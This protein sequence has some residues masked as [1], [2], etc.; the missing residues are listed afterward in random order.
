MSV[1][2]TYPATPSNVDESVVKPSPEF[3]KQVANTTGVI[4]LFLVVYIV[5]VAAGTALAAAC[6]IGGVL[7][8]IALPKFFTLML[9]VGLIGLG[10]M[11]LFFLLKFI[12]KQN[13]TDRSGLIEVTEEEQPELFDFIRTLTRETQAPFPKKIFLSPDVNACVF[14]DS[15]FWSMFLPVRKNLQ[16]GL[17]LVNSVN[18]SEFKAIMAHEFGHFSQRSMKL[19]SYVYNVNHVIYNMLYDNDGYDTT[20]QWWAGISDYF[21]LFAGMTVRIVRGIQWLLQQMY[22]VVNKTYMSLSRQMEFHADAVAAYVTGGDHLVTSLRRL[23]VADS[24]Y[25][26]LFRHYNS[27]YQENAKPDNIYPHHTEV[28]L[29]FASD[30]GVPIQHGL[31]HV[32]SSTFARFNQHRLMIKDQWASHPSTDD[33]E[34]HLNSLNIH[35]EAMTTPAWSIFR[36]AEKLQKEMTAM[37]YGEVVFSGPVHILTEESFRKKYYDEVR[38]YQLDRRYKG[39]FNDREVKFSDLN[40]TQGNALEKFEDI[41]SD[42]IAGLPLTINGLE[43]DIEGLKQ[44]MNKNIV[45]KTFDYDGR[46][47]EADDANDLHDRLSKELQQKKTELEE[48][49]KKLFG[50]FFALAKQK[51]K[52]A[53]LKEYYQEFSDSG[54]S[55]KADLENFIE[56]TSIMQP[57]YQPGLMIEQ[58]TAIMNQVTLREGSLKARLQEIIGDTSFTP[59]IRESMRNNFRKLIDSNW[60]YFDGINFNQEA[61]GVLNQALSDYNVV[62]FDRAMAAKKKILDWQLTLL[63]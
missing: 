1:A 10:L 45:V 7:L 33:R 62:A 39:F 27:W 35:T 25:R 43:S 23:E 14:Y 34:A 26:A 52:E 9:G 55:G 59:Y 31:L 44:I 53:E 42:A 36:N 40:M 11:V 54:T 24:C 50:Y 47:Y 30:H 5:L 29:H 48:A 15:G 41:L 51:G 60:A 38:Q 21:A 16:I 49:D 63:D 37:I 56:I 20:L 28:M 46:R 17:G 8:M 19:G 12:F 58:A 57:L 32:T 4:L 2:C 13:K 3:K 22:Q 6:A 18:M 61:L